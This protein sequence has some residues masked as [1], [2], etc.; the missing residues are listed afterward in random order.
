[1]SQYNIIMSGNIVDILY[2]SYVKPYQRY[3]LILF[4]IILFSIAGSYAYKW[5]AKPLIDNRGAENMS[6]NN[7]RISEVDIMFFSADWCPHCKTAK[8]Q[9]NQFKSEYNGT[10]KG[11][12]KINCVQV[13]CTDGDDPRIQEYSID[14]YPTIIMVKDQKRINYDAKITTSNLKQFIDQVLQ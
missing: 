9:W 14:G 4:L 3:L 6:N 2:Q 7:R 13:D 1:M 12:Y 10:E 11:F 5:F 8:P